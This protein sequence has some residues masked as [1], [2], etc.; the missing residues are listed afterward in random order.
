MQRPRSWPDS[1]LHVSCNGLLGLLWSAMRLTIEE[2]PETIKRYSHIRPA[3]VWGSV[4]CSAWCPGTSRNCTLEKD[5]KGPHVAHGFFRNVVA[6]WDE[7]SKVRKSE[8]SASRDLREVTPRGLRGKGLLSALMAFRGRIVR[9]APSIEEVVFLVFALGMV[10]F[11][12][13]WALRI[14][15]LK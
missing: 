6:V 11:A 7:R 1:H 14:M 15:M 13:D 9:R 3:F 5:H 4:R 12:I 8:V 2:N 10:W